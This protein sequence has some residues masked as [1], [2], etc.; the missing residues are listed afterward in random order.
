MKPLYKESSKNS[1]STMWV[2]QPTNRY[3]RFFSQIRSAKIAR[4]VTPVRNKKIVSGKVEKCRPFL[5][6]FTD[7]TLVAI[8]KYAWAPVNMLKRILAPILYQLFF[9]SLSVF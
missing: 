2:S 9:F 5:P 7:K 8:K 4:S 6:L 1:Y 3:K